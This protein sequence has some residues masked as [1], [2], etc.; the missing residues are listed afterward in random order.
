MIYEDVVEDVKRYITNEFRGQLA[1]SET[2]YAMKVTAEARFEA[3]FGFP[4]DVV[5]DHDFGI[6]QL[7][8]TKRLDRRYPDEVLSVNAPSSSD[9][10]SR[11]PG[12]GLQCNCPECTYHNG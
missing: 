8:V 9:D 11:Q 5:V 4:V 2:L 10:S 7:K 3:L 12:S 1:T 6:V